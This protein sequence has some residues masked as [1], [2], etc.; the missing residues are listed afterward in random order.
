MKGLNHTYTCIHGWEGVWGR[1][2]TCTYKLIPVLN[3]KLK[4]LIVKKTEIQFRM[5]TIIKL[6]SILGGQGNS[7]VD[8]EK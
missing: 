2:G 7:K 6:Q 5:S 4:N 8:L 1:M 3:S